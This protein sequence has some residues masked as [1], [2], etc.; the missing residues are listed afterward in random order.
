MDIFVLDENLQR[1]SIID[2][3]KSFIWTERFNEWGDFELVIHFS[4]AVRAALPIGTRIAIPYSMRVM[5]VE[6]QVVDVDD[7]GNNTITFTGRSLEALLDDRSAFFTMSGSNKNYIGVAYNKTSATKSDVASDYI[8][9]LIDPHSKDQSKAENL[10]IL[11]PVGSPQKYTWLKYADSPTEGMSN[12][13]ENKEY[14]GLAYDKSTQ[15]ESST[16][17]DYTWHLIKNYPGNQAIPGPPVSGQA[18]YTWIK[19]APTITGDGMTNDSSGKWV[20]QGP[21]ASLLR[22]IFSKV[23]VERV[24]SSADGIPFYVAG[25][26]TPP[27]DIPEPSED[28]LL[29]L[30]PS[31]LYEVTK[32]NAQIYNLGFRFVRNDDLGQIYYEIYTGSDRTSSQTTNPAVIFSRALDSLSDLSEVQSDVDF[33][34]VAY[35]YANNGS[36]IVYAPES[37]SSLASGFDRKILTVDASDIDLEAGSELNAALI[38]RG[39]KE[40]AAHRAILGFDGETP[41]VISY[42]Y[43][44]DYAL[45][46][47]VEVHDTEGNA[48]QMRVTEQIFASDAEGDRSYPTFTQ[49]QFV[50]S[51]SWM[52]YNGPPEWA[53]VPNTS[54]YEWKDM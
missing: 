39:H 43:G 29:E 19:Y 40:L 31:S 27:G 11:G 7:E 1:V 24:L 34:N 52:A 2:I 32:E 28:I 21:P 17:S 45:G 15:V 8:W 50:R 41:Q 13:P 51:G 25:T 23:C 44:Q 54:S 33:K 36:A 37:N 9:S 26:L 38:D 53:D 42:V 18:R 3:Y 10:G 6:T 5:T 20:L 35:V 49:N 4:Q 22:T 14:I 16:Y 48:N 12:S 46:D 30:E 47:L